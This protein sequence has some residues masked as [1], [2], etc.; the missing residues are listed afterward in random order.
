VDIH[1]VV[2]KELV[3]PTEDLSLKSLAKYARFMWRDETPGG[4]NSVAWY[5]QQL[6]EGDSPLGDELRQ[7]LLDYNEDDVAATWELREFISRMGEARRP[8]LKL[9]SVE[10]LDAKWGP[11]RPA[12]RRAALAGAA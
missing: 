11:R 10:S 7:R 1:R 8:G 2:S 5:R 12:R 4:A 6:E 9:P 3:W